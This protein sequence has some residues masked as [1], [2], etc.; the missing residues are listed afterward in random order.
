MTLYVVV[1]VPVDELL[2]LG[3]PAGHKLTVLAPAGEADPGVVEHLL[4]QRVAAGAFRKDE[5]LRQGAV[6]GAQALAGGVV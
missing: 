1:A 2:V 5:V 3:L 4:A 6:G